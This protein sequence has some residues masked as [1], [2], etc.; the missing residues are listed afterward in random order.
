MSLFKFRLLS[1]FA[2]LNLC[3]VSSLQGEES[4]EI[5]LT[6]YRDA[7]SLSR[8]DNIPPGQ[9]ANVED[10]YL[11]GYIQA[12]IDVHYY[13]F[14]VLVYVKDNEVTLY[15]LPN[16]KLIADSIISF[17]N[18]LPDVESVK[19]VKEGEFPDPQVLAI[20]QRIG[21]T[22]VKGIWFP[23]STVLFP[24]LIASPRNPIY[25]VG[26]R[27]G[28][29]FLA[30]NVASV[31]LG[32]VFPLFR[33]LD[34]G[35]LHADIQVDVAAC[36]WALFDMNVTDGVNHEWAELVNADYL[37]ALPITMAFDKWAFRLQV[38]H[39]SCHLGDEFIINQI[40]RQ[41]AV[42][43]VNPSFEV[44]ELI[45]SYQWFDN[46]RTYFGPGWVFHSDA[47][48]PMGDWYLQWGGELRYY[49]KRMLYHRLYGTPFLAVDVQNWQVNNWQCSVT[50]QLGYEWSKLHG[51]GRK[52]RFFA[53]FHNGNGEGQF[54]TETLQY[55]SINLS[56]GF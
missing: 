29:D 23:E 37:A 41:Q 55:T 53:Q 21:R 26:Y 33:W 8:T 18:D 54:F 13:E 45:G 22:K 46:L 14:E 17:V 11:E 20:E 51:V 30:S 10:H 47:S 35:P 50:A 42:N 34:V 49:G 19:A 6:G 40:R 39:I 31:S 24:P 28:N 27:F 3:F 32:D 2:F 4:E 12:L 36:T 7:K 52:V 1:V 15:H 5:Y 56:W 38:Y 25:S 9:L 48:Y 43:R 16:D 44:L